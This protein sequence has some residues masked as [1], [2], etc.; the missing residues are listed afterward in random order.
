MD[1]ND[2]SESIYNNSKVEKNYDSS[3]SGSH[4]SE[5]Q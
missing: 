2:I 3:V 5:Q 1:F 4:I